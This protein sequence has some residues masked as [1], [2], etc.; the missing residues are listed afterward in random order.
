MKIAGLLFGLLLFLSHVNADS[1]FHYG[2]LVDGVPYVFIEEEEMLESFK[3]RLLLSHLQ[4]GD[5]QTHPDSSMVLFRLQ[6]PMG[7]PSW[8]YKLW[9]IAGADKMPYGLAGYRKDY[10]LY[11]QLLHNEHTDSIF[12]LQVDEY[13]YDIK[14]AIVLRCL[15][16]AIP[17]RE[18]SADKADIRQI[19]VSSRREKRPKKLAALSNILPRIPSEVLNRQ[20]MIERNNSQKEM[21]NEIRETYEKILV[22]R[23]GIVDTLYAL[24]AS[25]AG[26][27]GASK[28]TLLIVDEGGKLLYRRAGR[29]LAR[30]HSTLNV[31][32][33]EKQELILQNGTDNS[34]LLYELIEV[35]YNKDE[36]KYEFETHFRK[37]PPNFVPYGC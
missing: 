20:R 15:P 5:L 22:Q 9:K 11:M 7:G 14:G 3:D 37:V 29:G 18:G 10:V 8:D 12:K 36:M 30:I 28:G 4:K 16:I 23:Y 13:F 21:N 27:E 17:Q 26:H 2:V 35:K 31:N 32:G 25:Y 1:K 19:V 34:E 33:D 6:E 24:M